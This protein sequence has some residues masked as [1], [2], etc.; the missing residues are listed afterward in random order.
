LEILVAGKALIDFKPLGQTPE[1]G[2]GPHAG[3]SPLNVAVGLSRLGRAAGFWGCLSRDA[4]APR[5]ATAG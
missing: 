1:A 2:F 4:L 3:G 5:A